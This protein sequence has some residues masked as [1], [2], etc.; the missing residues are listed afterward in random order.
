MDVYT[1]QIAK[2]RLVKKME[3][4]KA[5]DTTIKTGYKQ[6]APSW[7][8]VLGYKDNSLS[9]EK[10]TELYH[11][12]LER[13]RALHPAFWEALFRQEKIALGCY[14]KPS[15]FCHRH[16]LVAYLVAHANANYKGEIL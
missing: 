15:T 10:Y 5:I 13:S 12:M 7:S 6:L 2:W 1:Y 9:P 14:C 3:G 16:L 8:M 11:D 4:V